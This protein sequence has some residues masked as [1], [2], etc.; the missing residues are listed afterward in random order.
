MKCL[1]MRIGGV[2]E[3]R[4]RADIEMLAEL[5]GIKETQEALELVRQFYPESR[6]TP[7]TLFGIEEIFSGKDES[8]T[9]NQKPKHGE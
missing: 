1:A 3:T 8:S 2:D 7:K 5:L 6:I 9:R 4:D